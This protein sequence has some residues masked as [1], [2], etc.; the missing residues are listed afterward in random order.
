MIDEDGILYVIFIFWL[1]DGERKY[2]VEVKNGKFYYN[3]IVV[4]VRYVELGKLYI[5]LW[6]K[7]L[8]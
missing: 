1:K 8:L 6:V 5:I 3:V 4:L 2:V 7:I